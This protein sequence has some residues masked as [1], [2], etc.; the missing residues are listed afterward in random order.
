VLLLPGAD[1]ECLQI[2]L[3]ALGEKV[4]GHRVGLVMDGAGAHRAGALHWPAAI[5]PVPLPPYA[6]ELNPVERLLEHLRAK[7]ANRA[8]ADLEELVA[9]IAGELQQ[10]WE[11]P[12]RLRRLTGYPWWAEAAE[13]TQPLA[14]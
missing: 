13:S 6:P 14:S 7:L 3:D 1:A 8:F 9:A 10:F 2:L 11:E 12:R 4:A 5:V